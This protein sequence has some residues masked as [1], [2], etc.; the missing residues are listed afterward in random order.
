MAVIKNKIP[1][2]SFYTPLMW[3]EQMQRLNWILC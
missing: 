3:K 1:M 2:V